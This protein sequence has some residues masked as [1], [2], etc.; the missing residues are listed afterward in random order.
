M[1]AATND[2]S[3]IDRLRQLASRLAEIDDPDAAWISGSLAVYEAGASE[4]V[5]L[6]RALGIAPAPGQEGW[7]T[8]EGRIRRD[9]LLCEMGCRFYTDEPSET[10]QAIKINKRLKRFVNG[11]R[12]WRPGTVEEL[13]HYLTTEDG[14]A[15]SVRTIQRALAAGRACQMLPAI[16]G[17]QSDVSSAS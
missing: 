10:K 4:G 12:Q 16:D 8:R 3:H 6:C 14:K 9:T 7:W 15:P 5:T 17:T 11:A 2:L 1:A 13:C